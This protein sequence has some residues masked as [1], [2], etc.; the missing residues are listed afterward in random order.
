M[1]ISGTRVLERT[2]F[3][4]S[5]A[6]EYFS[7]TE[8]TAQ[9]GQDAKNF[10]VVI[11]KELIDNSLD[12]CETTARMPVIKLKITEYPTDK[13]KIVVEDNGNGISR[14][15]VERI[16]NFQTRTTSKAFYRTPTRGL[17]GNALKTVIGIPFALINATMDSYTTDPVTIDSQGYHHSINVSVDPTGMLQTDYNCEETTENNQGTTITVVIKPI[18]KSCELV[19]SLS[20]LIVGYAPFNPHTD[21]CFSFDFSYQGFENCEWIER[22]Y[23]EERRYKPIAVEDWYKFKPTD[24]PSPFWFK[25]EDL[26]K[27]IYAH[28]NNGRDKNLGAFIR[29][30]RGLTSTTKAR[31]VKRIFSKETKKLSDLSD[32]VD[33]QKLLTAMKEHAGNKQPSPQKA[34]GIIGEENFKRR[35]NEVYPDAI[36]EFW[37]AKKSGYDNNN[38]P[39]VAEAACVRLLENVV[40]DN[41]FIGLNFT[42]TYSDS[43]SSTRF[44]TK[45]KGNDIS[46]WGLKGLLQSLK[47]RESD[48]I[49]VVVHLTYPVFTFKDRA[50]N[51]VSLPEEVGAG[52][53]DVVAKACQVFF[54]HRLREE[55]SAAREYRARIKEEK[56]SQCETNRNKRDLKDA[57]FDLIPRAIAETSENGKYDFPNRNLFYTMRRLLNDVDTKKELTSS[58]FE[59][60]RSEYEEICGKIKGRYAEPRGEF[61][62]PHTKIVV[63]LG[64]MAVAEYIIPKY[65]F[66]KILYVEKRGFKPIFLQS[67]IAEKYDMGIAMGQGYAV[68]ACKELLAKANAEEAIDILCLHD[69]DI[70]GLRI[71]KTLKDS[72]KGFNVEIFDIGFTVSDVLREKLEVDP[73]GTVIKKRPKKLIETLPSDELN[74]LWDENS[75]FLDYKTGKQ[76]WSGSRVELNALPPGDLIRWIEKQ[77]SELKLDT[78]VCPSEGVIIHEAASTYNNA[79]NEQLTW[80]L[81]DVLDFGKLKDYIISD[82][83]KNARPDFKGMQKELEAAL[84]EHPPK[85]WTELIEQKT[86]KEASRVV[87]EKENEIIKAAK[88]WLQKEIMLAQCEER[89]NAKESIF[90]NDG[91]G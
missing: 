86:K 20:N 44:Q 64:T 12:G 23:V 39:F 13:L 43:F 73:E 53:A 55:K 14:E 47:I 65:L 84:E 10:P 5:R 58:Y 7:I 89:K 38:L 78:K 68:D 30:F 31:K 40:N 91:M 19:T 88:K 26:T 3:S 54:L 32:D 52:L 42:P 33:I 82:A 60:I 87:K 76:C 48:P 77:L 74:F 69:C 46:A 11:C 45:I 59:R 25:L 49:I 81:L 66:N 21:F 17:Q 29:E 56:E 2:D 36:D 34:L 6:L 79:L 37:Y 72:L 8:L 18:E 16:L 67:K 50:K 71:A 80:Q 90:T 1:S 4:I 61:M 27:L 57:C 51:T 9:T 63:P 22:K 24:F 85:R 70:D 28:I 75:K 83:L 41:L 35:L 15:V 62:E